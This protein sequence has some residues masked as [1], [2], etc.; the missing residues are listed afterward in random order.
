M[1][2][3]YSALQT[4]I[5]Q[6]Y[7]IVPTA[8]HLTRIEN[9]K[10]IFTDGFIYSKTKMRGRQF[11]DISN[12]NVQ[13]IRAQKQIPQSGR[14][15]HDY[16][17]LFVSYKAPMVASLQQHNEQL[18]YLEFSLDL[19]S[20]YVGTILADDNAAITNTQFH[21]FNSIDALTALDFS[22]IQKTVGYASDSEKAR[23]KSA[24]VL[25]P[26]QISA[27][28]IQRLAFFSS[29]SR[30]EGCRI[31]KACGKDIATFYRADWFFT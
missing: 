23:K 26:D 9:L 18:V 8:F 19:F 7:N 29:T 25:V 14:I 5:R 2:I 20:R 22:I 3:T 10:S 13:D 24:E 21:A 31:L 30:A 17:P 12:Q 6:R 15:L 28:E 27:N 11:T 16:V 4:E 1:P